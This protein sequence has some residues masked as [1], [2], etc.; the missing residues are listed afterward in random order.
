M[1]LCVRMSFCTS[2]NVS[3]QTAESMKYNKVLKKYENADS[4]LKNET[5]SQ[6]GFPG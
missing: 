1:P 2:T 5:V 6:A 3:W 4:A